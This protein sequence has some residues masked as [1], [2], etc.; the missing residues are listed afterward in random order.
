MDEEELLF[1]LNK[2]KAVGVLTAANGLI[3]FLLITLITVFIPLAYSVSSKTAD[4]IAM[5]S[6]FVI[7][8]APILVV[9]LIFY[10]V[11][12]QEYKQKCNFIL[13]KSLRNK[14]L[15]RH[16]RT[17]RRLIDIAREIEEITD[18]P[19]DDIRIILVRI[20]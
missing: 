13:V 7:I 2:D 17:H 12:Y 15:S 19:L 3:V 16:P 10:I 20:S 1:I 4:I 18:I 9:L 5:F 6:I 11:K 8:A 14:I